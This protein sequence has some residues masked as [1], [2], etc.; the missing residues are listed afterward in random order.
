MLLIFK[1]VQ[2][3][4]SFH[5]PHCKKLNSTFQTYLWYVC[6]FHFVL[7][8]LHYSFRPTGSSTPGWEIHQRTCFWVRFLTSS[9]KKTFWTWWPTPEKPCLTVFMSFRYYDLISKYIKHFK[10]SW[11]LNCESYLLIYIVFCDAGSAPWHT[12]PRPRSGHLLCHRRLWRC[13]AQQNPPQDKR[14]RS[15]SSPIACDTL[16]FL[17]TA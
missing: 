4:W 16:Y 17:L 11:C 3:F 2:G 9:E 7:W 1:N 10:S 12:E 15:E 14:Q 8:F 6:L 13:H 5:H